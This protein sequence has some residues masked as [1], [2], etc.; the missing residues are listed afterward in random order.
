MKDVKEAFD[1]IASEYDSQRRFVIPQME[2]FYGAAVW[3]AAWPA[4]SPAIL[5]IGA[6]TGL[7]SALL[8]QR[9][10]LAALTLL[11]ISGNMLEVARGRFAGNPRVR[12]LVADYSRDEIPGR[13]DL[14]CS[15]LS[16]HHLEDDDKR[17]LF[18]RIYHSLNPGG[19][20]VNADQAEAHSE[21]LARMNREYWDAFVAGSPKFQEELET[22]M[23]RRDTLDKNATL[24]DQVS[25][26]SEAGFSGVDI[27][28]KNRVFCVFVGK[29]E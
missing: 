3:A 17:R 26:L 24:L 7:F 23:V 25:W 1:A 4:E 12:F 13:Y 9:Y 28:Y 16:I 19:I 8:L 21:W 18:G 11:D 2:E 6:G 27:V 20:F 14:V 15:A 22:A 5:D 29:K 10:P